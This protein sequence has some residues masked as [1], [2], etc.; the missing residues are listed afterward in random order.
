LHAG[1]IPYWIKNAKRQKKELIIRAAPI[2][3][4][5]SKNTYSRAREQLSEG[6]PFVTSLKKKNNPVS[7]IP[8]HAKLS[9][10][11]SKNVSILVF[12]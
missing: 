9:S 5:F 12:N 3:E 10:K 4:V 7:H 1:H 2:L 11:Y 6:G 8:L